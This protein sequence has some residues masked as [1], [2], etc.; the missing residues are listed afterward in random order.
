[1]SLVLDDQ[2]VL[3][4]C[5]PS[6]C[7]Y[8]RP[9]HLNPTTFRQATQGLQDFYIWG[10]LV[11][12]LLNCYDAQQAIYRHYVGCYIVIS[13]Y[14]LPIEILEGNGSMGFWVTTLIAL[15]IPRH[16]Q[17]ELFWVKMS[18]DEPVFV[19]CVRPL[20]D[21]TGWQN[22]DDVSRNSTF[23]FTL[24]AAAVA[25]KQPGLGIIPVFWCN[26][27]IGYWYQSNVLFCFSFDTNDK[28]I[29]IQ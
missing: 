22:N 10:N 11:K 5:S 25:S 7:T 26:D 14:V 20:S 6:V 17:M 4:S 28:W 27:N 13:S 21:C 2:P 15:N 29:A 19:V 16:I 9:Q 8:D 1:M 18:K 12:T 24:V 23:M 3:S